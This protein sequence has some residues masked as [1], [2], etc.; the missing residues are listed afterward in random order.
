VAVALH[1]ELDEM[2]PGDLGDHV[3]VMGRDE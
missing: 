1:R 3:P 2:R